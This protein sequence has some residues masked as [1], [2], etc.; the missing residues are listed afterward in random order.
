MNL[1]ELKRQLAFGELSNL[2]WA[3][4]GV[5]QEDR[6]KYVEEFI[7][8]TLDIL[9]ERFH[10]KT[11]SV[12]LEPIEGKVEYEISNEHLLS[13]EDLEPDYDHYLFLPHEDSFNGAILKIIGVVDMLG[14]KL[15]IN[16]KFTRH[17]AFTPF[18]NVLVIPEHCANQGIELEIVLLMG[19]PDLVNDDTEIEITQALIPAVRAYVAYLIHSNMNTE[20]AVTNAQKYLAQFNNVLAE[21]INS[22]LTAFSKA[23]HEYAVKFD[24]RGWI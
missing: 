8:E 19:H 16:D 7:K 10:L 12:Y 11:K 14:H 9:Y 18:Y 24:S 20:N 22:D 2:I 6:V 5:I 21:N 1:G 15:P 13:Q 17:S 23:E 3:V 4:N